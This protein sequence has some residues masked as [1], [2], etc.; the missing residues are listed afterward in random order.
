[1]SAPVAVAETV[2]AAPAHNLTA[3]AK[4][5]VAV[6]DAMAPAIPETR[7]A[8]LALGDLARPRMLDA[9]ATA[10]GVD[11]EAAKA[12]YNAYQ[13]ET[14]AAAKAKRSAEH[15]AE[16][17]A[18][19]LVWNNAGKTITLLMNAVRESDSAESAPADK[20]DAD[21]LAAV[22]E[23]ASKLV[24]RTKDAAERAT[25]VKVI[26]ASAVKVK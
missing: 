23:S 19:Y 24:A 9:F 10:R 22:L 18:L 11:P 5:A 21:R 2:A 17:K 1:M 8:M 13:N 6:S 20:T 12:A 25:M 15:P 26:K 16:R 4:L 7:A 3:W 14:R